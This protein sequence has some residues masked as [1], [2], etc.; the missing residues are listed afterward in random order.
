MIIVILQA[1]L[2]STRYSGKVLKPILGEPMVWRQ[3]ERIQRAKAIDGIVLATSIDSSDDELVQF[4]NKKNEKI[5]R[6]SLNN[7]LTRYY[8]C[9]KQYMPKHIVR[10]CADSPLV[11]PKVIDQVV[12]FH[13]AENN[14]YTSNVGFPL[15]LNVEVMK[16]SALEDAYQNAQLKSQRE[17]V[18][19]YIY[20]HPEKFKISR[21][22][23]YT[24]LSEMRWTVD[25]L[26]DFQ[27]VTK[28]YE[29]IYPQNFDFDMSDVLKL[30][31]KYPELSKINSH[32][33]PSEGLTRSLEKDT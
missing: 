30:L 5:Y 6:G 4:F 32:F 9:A 23:N 22:K 18:T 11:D 19:L 27:F 20:Q 21:L 2:S 33:N 8:Q 15:G 13:V 24:D 31:K 17:H 10:L 29:Q 26:E 7:V 1:R 3:W 25:Y 12:N 14:D 16:F 28:V